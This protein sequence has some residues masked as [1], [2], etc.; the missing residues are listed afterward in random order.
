[1]ADL[2]RR[3]GQ[4]DQ[5]LRYYSEALLLSS[6]ISRPF[7]GRAFVRILQGDKKNAVSDLQA[8]CS[9]GHQNACHILETLMK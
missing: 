9:L 7:A 6:Q 3:K 1:M 8:A 4:Y 5:A 2:F